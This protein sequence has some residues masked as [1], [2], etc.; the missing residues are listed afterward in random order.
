MISEEEI[1]FLK[2]SATLIIKALNLCELEIDVIKFVLHFKH[3]NI[4]ETAKKS[5]TKTKIPC[6]SRSG[7]LGLECFIIKA[8]Y[9]GETF[10]SKEIFSMPG[11]SRRSI[12][13]ISPGSNL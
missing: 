13:W 3:R 9:E 6:H 7:D 2:R 4:F 1:T 12:I 11:T 5:F 8:Y 10:L